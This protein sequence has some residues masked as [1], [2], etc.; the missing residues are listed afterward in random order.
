MS[1]RQVYIIKDS[2]YA[3]RTIRQANSISISFPSKL[4]KTTSTSKKLI[5]GI[6]LSFILKV[7]CSTTISQVPI[8]INF[9]LLKLIKIGNYF[10]IYTLR[11]LFMFSTTPVSQQASTSAY[12]RS[13]PLLSR[14][15][16]RFRSTNS[17]LG[18]VQ[19]TIALPNVLNI[20][21][22]PAR[23]VS[24]ALSS[25]SREIANPIK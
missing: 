4:P 14:A 12:T 18:S 13:T 2:N 17:L 6:Y 3:R 8:S 23:T 5:D 1:F 22:I 10:L 11:I 9:L 16:F 21:L 15:G 20:F 25:N 24:I 19:R 7:V